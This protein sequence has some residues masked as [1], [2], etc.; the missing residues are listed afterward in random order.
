MKRKNAKKKFA[1]SLKA[2]QTKLAFPA[3]ILIFI[4][5]LNANS[6]CAYGQNTSSIDLLLLLDTSTGMSSSY[7]NVNNYLTGPFLTEFLRVGDTFHFIPFSE[8]PKLD[9]ARRI[10]GIGDVETIIA[11]MYLHYPIE[12]G[13]NV[14][15]ALTY[16]EE[17]ITSLP[18]RP[19]KIVLITCGSDTN[20]LAAASRTRLSSRNTTVDFIQ[21]TAGQPLSNLPNSRR[22]PRARPAASTAQTGSATASNTSTSPTTPS[23][24]AASSATTTTSAAAA[25]SATTTPSA[26]AAT[27]SNSATT[28]TSTAPNTTATTA[29]STSTPSAAAATSSN[30]STTVSSTA[31]NTAQTGIASSSTSATQTPA[32]TANATPSGTATAATG[33]TSPSGDSQTAAASSQT[34]SGTQSAGTQSVGTQNQTQSVTSETPG[35]TETS[36][37]AQTESAQ[38]GSA[39]TGSARSLNSSSLLFIIGIIILVLL[40]LG[41]LIFLLSRKLRSSPNRLMSQ[42]S[43]SDSKTK[44]KSASSE[45]RITQRE[46]I[47][48]A[49]GSSR[50]TTPYDDRPAA[51]DNGKPV[52]INPSGPLLLN[53]FVEEQ[54]TNIGKR[55]IHSL[56]SGYS[57]TVGG[58]KSDDYNIFLVPIP[59]HVGEIRRDESQLIFIP[60]KSKYFPD[61][62]A[63][64]VKDCIN[65]TIRIISDKNYEMRFRFVMY[66]DPLI[67]L[68]RLLNSVRVPG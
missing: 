48:Y 41:L 28:A 9:A 10:S 67:A 55:N 54:N 32:T 65:K 62:G 23:A 21:V 13:N 63:N 51:T 29:P 14:R 33:I 38:T 34:S 68:N 50:R 66:E 24:V 27:S 61:I 36:S 42:A 30:T 37:S 64:E 49:S 17:Y 6:V 2:V 47:N 31:P 60:K 16:A 59:A 53:L 8:T 15:S 3:V 43:D 25:S 4:I 1:S 35:S 12:N 11:R 19:K 46:V 39:Q 40:L 22:T 52:V 56:K 44:T 57:L 45:D 5:F 18:S 58:G 7:D 26:A 20:A